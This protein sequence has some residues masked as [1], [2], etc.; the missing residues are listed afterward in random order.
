MTSQTACLLRGHGRAS[1]QN[2]RVGKRFPTVGSTC[3]THDH[4]RACVR[5]TSTHIGAAT[6]LSFCRL[7]RM[8][9][10]RILR[11]SR[12]GNAPTARA[13]AAF[14][15]VLQRPGL[16]LWPG[17]I[18]LFLATKAAWSIHPRLSDPPMPT[19]PLSDPPTCP[20]RS[21]MVQ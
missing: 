11:L 6:F 15:E 13:D 20:S 5:H 14:F 4:T 17:C 2:D 19:Q 8:Q 1:T 18:D 7:S 10:A 12:L 16:G 21:V 3:P 9:R